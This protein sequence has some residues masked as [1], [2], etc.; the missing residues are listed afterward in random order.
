MFRP[1][2]EEEGP[3]CRSPRSQTLG[4][5]V[6]SRA[7]RDDAAG[8]DEAL[9][10]EAPGRIVSPPPD[11]KPDSLAGGLGDILRRSRAMTDA[12]KAVA[13]LSQSP[14]QSL[15]NSLSPP[16]L[17]P[18]PPPIQGRWFKDQTIHVDGFTF[19]RCRFDNC[20]IVTRFSTFVFR[21]CFLGPTT[22]VFFDGPA[23]KAAKLLMFD[24]VRKGRILA[25]AGETGIFPAVKPDG[26]VTLE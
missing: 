13:S 25:Q 20:K 6:P 1:D 18:A 11:D 24:L 7:V 14:L 26:T 4:E 23:L 10:E 3:R 15:L 2:G 5:R 19:E 12:E 21:D 17:P 22:T 9:G 16:P 8:S